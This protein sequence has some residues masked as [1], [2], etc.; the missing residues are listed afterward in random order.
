[1]RIGSGACSFLGSF[2]FGSSAGDIG[3]FESVSSNP[4][5]PT[6]DPSSEPAVLMPHDPVG[7]GIL[8]HGKRGTGT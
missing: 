5:K 4:D 8:P 6:Y 1:M 7:G 2:D 3:A